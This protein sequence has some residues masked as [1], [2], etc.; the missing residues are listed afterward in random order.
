MTDDRAIIEKACRLDEL[1][2]QHETAVYALKAGDY[3]EDFYDTFRV[4]RNRKGK[5]VPHPEPTFRGALRE[6][7]GYDVWEPLAEE[8]EK[9]FGTPVRVTCIEDDEK[10]RDELGPKGYAPFFF[11]FDVLF[12]EYPDCTLCFISGTNN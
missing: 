6:L 7:A 3:L 8:T 2:M 1:G 11:V 9:T 12:A 5:L 10:L 4:R